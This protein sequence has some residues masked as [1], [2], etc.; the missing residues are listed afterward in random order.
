MLY[1]FSKNIDI[2]NGGDYNN[3]KNRQY[4]LSKESN[5]D[6][7]LMISQSHPAK[8]TPADKFSEERI[9]F[10]QEFKIFPFNS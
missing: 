10:K 4:T 5:K 8:F 9:A 1:H 7:N 3:Y 6:E 2:F